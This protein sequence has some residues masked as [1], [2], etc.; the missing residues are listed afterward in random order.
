MDRKVTAANKPRKERTSEN[1]VDDGAFAMSSLSVCVDVVLKGI[2]EEP[3]P[4]KGLPRG[5]G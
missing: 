4:V 3:A 2:D 1:M 5:R